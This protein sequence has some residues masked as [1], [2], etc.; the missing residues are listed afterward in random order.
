MLGFLD[1]SS[2]LAEFVERIELTNHISCFTI[3]AG[4]SPIKFVANEACVCLIFNFGSSVSVQLGENVNVIAPNQYNLLEM[5]DK[6]VCL[7]SFLSNESPFLYVFT[8][9]LTYF[10]EIIHFFSIGSNEMK[11]PFALQKSREISSEM[12]YNVWTLRKEHQSPEE[13]KIYVH[14]KLLTILAVMMESEDDVRIDTDTKTDIPVSTKVNLVEELIRADWNNAYSIKE[15]TKI[16]GTNECYLKRDFKAVYG[17]PIHAYRQDKKMEYAKTLLVYSEE[18]IKS[19]SKKIR[20][21][22]HHTFQCGI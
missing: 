1:K 10:N 9:P 17:K 18:S 2:N 15:L 21:Q 4:K 7:I 12:Q 19:I 16:A 13:Q 14:G 3:W 6:D 11:Y 20:L 22:I 5:M 8:L